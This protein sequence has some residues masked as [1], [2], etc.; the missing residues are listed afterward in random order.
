MEKAL[1]AAESFDVAFDY[2][3]RN[4]WDTKFM[5][6]VGGEDLII[7]HIMLV[8]ATVQPILAFHFENR[9]ICF[10]LIFPRGTS[11][12]IVKP[13]VDLMV[14]R[15]EERKTTIIP[16]LCDYVMFRV[17]RPDI[18]SVF[19]NTGKTVTFHDTIKPPKPNW[20]FL[21]ENSCILYGKVDVIIKFVRDTATATATTSASISEEVSET[22]M[23]I[24][25]FDKVRDFKRSLE[26][27]MPVDHVFDKIE[28]E[29]NEQVMSEIL[30]LSADTFCITV[31]I[32]KND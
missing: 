5:V 19:Y 30:N 7:R 25:T 27:I 3:L 17:E 6:Y 22:K 13:I 11:Y 15:L 29:T 20:V 9:R 8:V 2:W 28:G 14:A 12:L 18:P 26:T 16:E 4:Q 32:R 1:V 24:R 21:C 10:Q 31:K 23:K